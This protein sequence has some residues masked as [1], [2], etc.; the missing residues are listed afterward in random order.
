M[1]IIIRCKKE[2]EMFQTV[3]N[4][5]LSNISRFSYVFDSQQVECYVIFSTRNTVYKLSCALPDD[6]RLWILEI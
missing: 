1:G 5:K 6:L 2:K 4:I 3:E